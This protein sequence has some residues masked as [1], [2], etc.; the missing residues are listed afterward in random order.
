MSHPIAYAMDTMSL[1]RDFGRI[2]LD[3]KPRCSWCGVPIR[4]VPRTTSRYR[5]RA[6]CDRCSKTRVSY[7]A[8]AY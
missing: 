2:L 7:D 8:T 5:H 6:Y 1:G 4:A 3:G